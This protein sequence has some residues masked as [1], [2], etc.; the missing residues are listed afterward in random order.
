VPEPLVQVS[1]GKL[2]ALA[3]LRE[4]KAALESAR[5]SDLDVFSLIGYKPHE[6]QREFHDATEDD[7]LYGGSAGGGKAWPS[8]P[9]DSA[10]APGTRA[11][12]YC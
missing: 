4:Q 12:A 6:K 2:A 5:M 1:A 9:R 8:W 11:F 3:R 7:V 10:P